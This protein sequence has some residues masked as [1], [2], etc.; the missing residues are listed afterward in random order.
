MPPSRCIFSSL[1]ACSYWYSNYAQCSS[2]CLYCSGGTPP[3]P[4]LAYKCA[5]SSWSDLKLHE[6]RVTCRE[7][8]DIAV[9][10]RLRCP[11]CVAAVA[12]AHF[13]PGQPTVPAPFRR[14][15]VGGGVT[16]SEI[17]RDVAGR[18]A[19]PLR[20]P[21]FAFIHWVWGGR[22]AVFG[23]ASKTIRIFRAWSCIFATRTC[24]LL[25][26][27]VS[28]SF[29][30]PAVGSRRILSAGCCS[31][32]SVRAVAVKIANSCPLATL[33]AGQEAA[34]KQRSY[35]Q[36]D[37]CRVECDLAGC[38]AADCVAH[39]SAHNFGDTGEAPS[40]GE[41]IP[42]TLVVVVVVVGV[43]SEC[44]LAMVHTCSIFWN[45]NYE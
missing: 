21:F 11:E 19:T 3:L 20:S 9:P 7:V 5:A 24:W 12:A 33:H 28:T 6:G 36:V 31:W 35:Y 10:R 1:K 43:G 23:I 15:W 42:D 27:P 18:C 29:P 8:L 34:S 41:G 25:G 38:T 22:C 14:S 44:R 39:C 26:P 32:P 30:L 17:L 4:P 45:K 2:N 40:A 13:R 37:R 16:F